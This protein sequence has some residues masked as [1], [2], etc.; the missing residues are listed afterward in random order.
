MSHNILVVGQ[1]RLDS[2][3]LAENLGDCYDGKYRLLYVPNS[4]EAFN[5]IKEL[6]KND[7]KLAL[8]CVDI[9]TYSNGGNQLMN[10]ISDTH[11]KTRKLMFVHKGEEIDLLT[12]E[13]AT[14]PL[15]ELEKEKNLT[16]MV[17]ELLCS[18]E[19]IP[20]FEYQ[21]NGLSIKMADTLHEKEEFFKLR[22]KVYLA[23]KHITE[24]K[25]SP[26]QNELGMEWDEY[27]YGGIDKIL[28]DAPTQYVI[29][30]DSGKII[31]GA[32]IVR[33][34]CPMETGICVSTG[35]EFNLEKKY[36]INE[37][38]TLD[39]MR[40]RGMNTTEVSRLIVDKEYREG[41]SAALVS[42]FRL[43]SH[44]TKDENYLVCT[45]KEKQAPLY[46]AIGFQIMGPKISYSLSGIW[47]PML[48]DKETAEKK[49]EDI[50]GMSK[51]FHQ[52]VTEPIP[53]CHIYSVDKVSRA[54]NQEATKLG[55]YTNGTS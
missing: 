3:K 30:K 1:E 18:Y 26:L 13:Q 9:G 52:M 53:D 38:F 16:D 47:I 34:P 39:F 11:P 33:G 50:P 37:P 45:A 4:K 19:D 5:K 27:D 23:S 44:L 46:Q 51:E 8:A 48:G 17:S 7:Q 29:A 49:P 21:V 40:E 24:D 42:I 25:L 36:G 2:S 22:R 12:E 28:L 20:N 10:W 41:S 54:V 55:L 14:S 32:R 6:D 31:G 15:N 43:V 35:E